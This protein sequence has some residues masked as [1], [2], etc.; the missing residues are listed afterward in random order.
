MQVHPEDAD[1]S[2]E[3]LVEIG[4]YEEAAQKWIEVP[5]NPKFRSKAGK[6]HSQM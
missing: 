4:Q 3:P 1:E 2:I 5:N 6:S